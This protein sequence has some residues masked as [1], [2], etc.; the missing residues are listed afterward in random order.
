MRTYL[1]DYF[2]NF[3]P[4]G[5]ARL[6]EAVIAIGDSLGVVMGEKKES[7]KLVWVLMFGA[8]CSEGEEREL[9][10]KG[11]REICRLVGLKRWVDVREI[12][13]RLLWKAGLDGAGKGV[14]E[15]VMGGGNSK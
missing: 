7:E 8:V 15:E 6:K 1:R 13:G 5:V 12:L 9:F 10:V 3:R 11:S 2:C 14:W 4:I